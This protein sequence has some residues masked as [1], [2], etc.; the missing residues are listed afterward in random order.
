MENLFKLTACD[1][2]SNLKKGEISPMEL[3]DAAEERIR[4]TDG[5]INALP[6]LCLDRARKNAQHIME[7]PKEEVP[8]GYLHGLPIAVKDLLE[9]FEVHVLEKQHRKIGLFPF[10]FLKI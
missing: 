7:H 9:I 1:A 4:K 3:I 2:V 10:L 8:P 6:T 5:K